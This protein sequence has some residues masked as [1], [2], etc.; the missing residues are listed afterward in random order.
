MAT[1]G[2]VTG[3]NL[4]IASVQSNLDYPV[5]INSPTAPE[6]RPNGGDLFEGDT[7]YSEATGVYSLYIK[8]VWVPVGGYNLFI[9]VEELEDHEHIVDGGPAAGNANPDAEPPPETAPMSD[10][11][12]VMTSSGVNIIVEESTN[13]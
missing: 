4:V 12:V 9:R 8:S 3:R 11:P 6:F 10:D 13:Y 2:I 7:W 1:P 5:F